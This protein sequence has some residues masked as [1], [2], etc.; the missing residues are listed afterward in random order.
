MIHSDTLQTSSD[1][2]WLRRSRL[3]AK[4]ISPRDTPDSAI[5]FPTLSSLS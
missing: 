1:L 5:A 4:K 3:V 2:F